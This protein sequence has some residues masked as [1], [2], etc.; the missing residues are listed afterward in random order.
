MLVNL[1]RSW[2]ER[3]RSVTLV[4]FSATRSDYYDLDRRIDRIALGL[5][6]DSMSVVT[7]IRSN[8]VRAVALRRAIA[9]C[10]PDVVLSFLDVTNV[11]TLL[12]TRALAVPVIVAE[13]TFPGAHAIGRFRDGLRR[14][15]YR[16]ASTVVTQTE[17]C[18]AWIRTHTGARRTE[19]IRN[20]LAPEFLHGTVSIERRKVVLAVGRLGR[21]K[22]FDLLIRAWAL[23]GETR[24]GWCLRIVGQGPELANLR[25]LACALGIDQTVETPGQISSIGDEY[26]V[27]S[28]YVLSSRYE[29]YPN[30]LI[31]AL[32]SGCFCV[33]FD[34]RTGPREILERVGSGTLVN[35]EDIAGLARAIEQAMKADLGAAARARQASRT[36]AEFSVEDNLSRWESVLSAAVASQCSGQQIRRS[37][38]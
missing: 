32:A 4:T 27:A 14:V 20:F 10:N 19:V 33:A 3:G 30:A 2:V 31:E 36:Q 22:G 12:S 13:R 24:R 1:C 15:A 7:M 6:G 38:P 16:W 35:A 18:A 21:E 34:C 25:S 9:G 8:L 11:L 28:V 37:K 5:V 26:R 29:G 17:E 23:I